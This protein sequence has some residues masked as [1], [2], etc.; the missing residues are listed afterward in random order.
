ME[1]KHLQIGDKVYSYTLV[2]VTSD[3]LAITFFN[4][5]EKLNKL[6]VKILSYDLATGFFAFAIDNK[7]FRAVVVPGRQYVDVLLQAAAKAVRCK[8]LNTLQQGGSMAFSAECG[9]AGLGLDLMSPLSG[10]VV[11]IFIKNGD[12]VKSATPLLVIESMK[13]EN[14]IYASRD[15]VIKNVFISVGDL[16]KQNQKLVGFKEAGELYGA[17]QTTSEF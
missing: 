14:V 17:S 2:F 13:M 4:G 8:K 11:E 15:A 10:R 1:I 12:F 16:V 5:L 9:S 6:Q 7:V 3:E